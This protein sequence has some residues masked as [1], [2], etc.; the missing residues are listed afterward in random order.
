MLYLLLAATT[1]AETITLG[2][3]GCGITKK[4]FMAELANAWERKTGIHI[5]LEGS[6]AAKASVEW[7]S[8]E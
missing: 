2:R 5:E 3:A 6:G 1:K 4:A 8:L 7:P